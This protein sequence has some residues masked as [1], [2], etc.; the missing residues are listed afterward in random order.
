MIDQL[1]QIDNFLTKP[2]E[3]RAMALKM[4]Y[5][6]SDD[7]TGWKGYRAL[8]QSNYNDN[9]V[10]LVKERVDKAL[11]NTNFDTYFHYTLESTKKD[12]PSFN[13]NKIHRDSGMDYAGVLY[14]TPDPPTNSG[15]VFYD[16]D[17]NIIH[18]VENIYNRLIFYPSRILHAV[19]DTFGDTIEN[20]RLTFTIFVGLPQ[21]KSKSLL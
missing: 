11:Y 16:D 6:P 12:I 7:T 17:Y 15:T 9:L 21:K 18:K 5:T 3:I 2:D 8:G 10:E 1:I 14:L 20:G 4:K 19:E 13:K